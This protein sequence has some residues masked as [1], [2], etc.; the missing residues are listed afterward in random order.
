MILP[1]GLEQEKLAALQEIVM[2]YW[3]GTNE[4]YEISITQ[5]PKDSS[6]VLLRRIYTP[7]IS[8]MLVISQVFE[9]Q[10]EGFR[11]GETRKKGKAAGK[12]YEAGVYETEDNNIFFWIIYSGELGA[13]LTPSKIPKILSFLEKEAKE[14]PIE[15]YNTGQYENALWGM[16]EPIKA[17]GMLATNNFEES[18]PNYLKRLENGGRA[19][20]P[21][22]EMTYKGSKVA[23]YHEGKLLST[24]GSDNYPRNEGELRAYLA[25]VF[26]PLGYAVL[27]GLVKLRKQ[28][29]KR[30]YEVSLTELVTIIFGSKPKGQTKKKVWDIIKMFDNTRIEL[31]RPHGKGGK[32]KIEYPFNIV[33]LSEKIYK[34]KDSE[35]P[36]RILLELFPQKSGERFKEMAIPGAVM[37]LSQKYLRLFFI[38]FLEV[39]HHGQHEIKIREAEIMEAAQLGKTYKSFPRQ[40]RQKLKPKLKHIEETTEIIGPLIGF[41]NGY[42]II[43]PNNSPERLRISGNT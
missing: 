34:E 12:K 37:D 15:K 41:K 20:N 10:Q 31:A 7:K 4:D 32:G 22:G 30:Y 36:D 16:A 39:K 33:I 13:L 29:N 2:N 17:M 14:A 35:I 8:K 25:N 1:R 43:S 3:G 5:K 24:S 18:I 23:V 19:N 6:F 40:A 21:V 38:L 26:G 11:L 28:V 42:V 9:P 27:I